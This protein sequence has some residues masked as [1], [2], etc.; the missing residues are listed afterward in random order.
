MNMMFDRRST[1]Q[2]DLRQHIEN[3]TVDG[4]RAI[5]ERRWLIALIVFASLLVMSIIVLQIP[6]SFTAEALIE[7][8]KVGRDANQKSA[9]IATIDG[10]SLVTSDVR[11]IE[12]VVIARRV[13]DR[14]NLTED[15][16]FERQ[17]G[18]LATLLDSVRRA[19]MP[20][21][22]DSTVKDRIARRLLQNLRINHDR[23]S[24]LI[25]I[26]YVA[27]EADLAAR[28]ANAFAIEFVFAKKLGRY[29]TT[30]ITA[31]E[32][33]VQ[34]SAVHGDR[35]PKVVDA[36]SRVNATR[37]QLQFH[38]DRLHAADTEGFEGVTLARAPSRPSG[39]KGLVILVGTSVAALVL[40]MMLA[41]WLGREGTAFR[42]EE[43]AS[44]YTGV[45]HIAMLPA[46]EGRTNDPKRI[47]A[48]NETL[49][50][51]AVDTKL[52][53]NSATS[54]LVMVT[55]INSNDNSDGIARDLA[56]QLHEHGC[57][58]MVIHTMPR[59]ETIGWRSLDKAFQSD[60]GALTNDVDN[61]TNPIVLAP[62]ASRLSDKPL[63]SFTRE[64]LQ[65]IASAQSKFDTIIVSV[66]AVNV[67][68]DAVLLGRSA[69]VNIV[70]T[71]WNNTQK[72]QIVDAVR[73][74]KESNLLVHAIALGETNPK[75][76][77]M[78]Q[79]WRDVQRQSPPPVEVPSDG[80]TENLGPTAQRIASLVDRPEWRHS[81]A[82]NASKKLLAK[83][84]RQQ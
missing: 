2:V 13:V 5:L 34:L 53:T 78:M 20:E 64:E 69:N 49:R 9:P 39:P 82:A 57:K 23:R 10:A 25:T 30:L 40:G 11:L 41:I 68:A 27:P 7:P 79:I 56:L 47:E 84:Q 75:F 83:F 35:H 6:R 38:K 46:I 37:A 26:A 22:L 33:V 76:C 12:S 74:L 19:V 58:V 16:A 24:Y 1:D 36:K 51:L 31:M 73:R 52:A 81:L 61:T 32:D 44:N 15:P 43:E 3:E 63:R 4:I 29:R 21:T 17:S 45:H 70:A 8:L 48:R 62:E 65:W 77:K 42:S 72:R 80:S 54:Q 60:V 14:L 18:S 71:R 55:G 67:S 59:T 50:M 66:P 28:I